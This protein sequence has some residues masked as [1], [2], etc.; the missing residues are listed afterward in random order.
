M[1]LIVYG[2]FNCPF[3]YLASLRADRLQARG[4]I[5]LD[6]RAVVH[7]PSVPESGIAVDGE[8]AGQLEE[9]LEHVRKLLEP[10]EDY[11]AR[12]PP[13]QPNTVKAV[14]GYASRGGHAHQLRRSVFSALWA[15]GEDIGDVSV[16]ERLG[17]PVTAPGAEMN[18]WER[19]W[20]S[21]DVRVVP[22]LVLPGGR[23][24]SGVDAIRHLSEIP[25]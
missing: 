19:E 16:L 15:D 10:G 12:R 13:V 22:T 8:L 17:C 20:R 25:G 24:V 14:A 1:E 6:W 9:E 3:S 11:P 23:Q 4:E 5:E 21:C 2:S 7:D 18:A